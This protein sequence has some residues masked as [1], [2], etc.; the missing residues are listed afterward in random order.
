MCSEI[1]RGTFLFGFVYDGQRFKF[2]L[3]VGDFTQCST[4]F[5]IL[6]T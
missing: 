6:T 2:A 3:K 1:Q 5:K 4:I